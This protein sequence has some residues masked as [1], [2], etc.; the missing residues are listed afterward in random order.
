MAPKESLTETIINMGITVLL[1]EFIIGRG[2][3]LFII[4]DEEKEEIVF[5]V[6][7]IGSNHKINE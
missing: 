3:M 1:I 4:L 7:S 6:D 5:I 2:R